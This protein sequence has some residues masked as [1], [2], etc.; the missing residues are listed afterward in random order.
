MSD[1]VVHLHKNPEPGPEHGDRDH[2]DR[3]P[4]AA[5]AAPGAAV[6]AL[7]TRRPHGR[8]R[9]RPPRRPRRA[10]ARHGLYVVGGARIVARR[11]GTAGPPPATSGCSARRK[12][13]GTARWPPSGRSACSASA[14]PATAAA[15]TCSTP[16]STRPRAS[17][18][19]PAWASVACSLLGIVLAIANKDIA[20]VVTP[21]MR[22][23][24]VHPPAHPIVPG[25]LGA[26]PHDRP[27][28][29]PARP[30]G[31]RQQ[32]Q[33][34]P[35]VGAARQRPRRRGRA[36]H[37]V[38][39]GQGPARPR[40]R[41]RCASAIKEMGDAGAAHARPDPDRRMRRGSRRHP[42]LR[43]LHERGP[44]AAPQARREPRPGTST[45]CSSP[46]RPPPAPSGCGSPTPA[47][48]TSRS[49]RLRWSPTR[50]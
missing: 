24:R 50:R 42:A 43:G 26:G 6:G 48:W 22:R 13:R 21:I 32:Q 18:S 27:V 44:E 10:V 23:D 46:S 36:D 29:R 15:W 1:N 41:P 30:V 38:D 16:P 25:G 28:A 11:T 14:R 33:A 37:P 4:D 49:A 45:R 19:A 39:R 8:H 9:T 12:P 5:P 20:D 40:R 17:R 31:G 2:P 34:A 7:R 35:A 3:G 47:R